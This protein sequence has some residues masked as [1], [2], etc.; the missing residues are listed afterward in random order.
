MEAAFSGL[1]ARHEVLRTRFV[2]GEGGRPVQVVDRP[3]PVRMRLLDLSAAGDEE[4]LRQAVDAEA[5]RGFDLAADALLRVALIRVSDDDHVLV[6]AMHHIVSDGWSIGVLAR[7]LSELYAAALDGR[8]AELP[9]LPVQYADFALW[10]REWL[11]GEILDRQLGYWSK[12]LAGLEPFELATDHPRPPERTGKGASFAFDVPADLVAELRTLANTTGTSLYMVL[13]AAFDVLLGRYGRRDD[14][15]VGT[16]IAG[17]N[18]AEIEGLIGFFVNTLV[19]RSD[20]SGNPRFEDLLARVKDTTL[21][22]YDHQ[23][24]P[25]E[26]LVEELAPERDLSRTPSSRSCSSCRTPATKPG[27]SPA[28]P[29]NPRHPAK[30]APPSTSS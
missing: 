11:Q 25:F 26:R 20:L 7:E 19:I 10:Q 24:L 17:R 4:R 12:Q 6:L 29:P 1:V 27:S 22:A 18:R 15:A 23:D 8:D 5:L 28:S 3:G 2:M 9:E 16:P 14:V 30:P 21:A 13:L